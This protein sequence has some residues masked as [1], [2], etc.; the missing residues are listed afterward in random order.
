MFNF[1]KK[2]EKFQINEFRPNKYFLD[3]KKPEKAYFCIKNQVN[4][5]FMK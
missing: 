3:V 2:V 4:A 1:Y 5:N